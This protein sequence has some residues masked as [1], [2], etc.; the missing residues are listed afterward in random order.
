MCVLN[1]NRG[2][3]KLRNRTKEAV[4]RLSEA[5]KYAQTNS[6]LSERFRSQ[7]SDPSFTSPEQFG[8]L[9]RKESSDM[10]KLAADMKFEKQ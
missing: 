5:L 3:L 1:H 10:A 2:A 4:Q 8:A 9:L 6:E 7:G